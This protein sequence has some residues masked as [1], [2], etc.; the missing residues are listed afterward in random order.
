M[1]LEKLDEINIG[2]R[3]FLQGAASLSLLAALE[4]FTPLYAQ[5][6]NGLAQTSRRSGE[7]IELVIADQKI[8]FDGRT[9]NAIT[10]NGSLPGPVIRLREGEDV[11]IRVTNKLK[12]TSSIHWHGLLV[13]PDMDG[14][15]GVSFAGI[16]PGETFTYRFPVNQYGTYWAHS[17]SGGQELMGVYAPLIIDPIEPEPFK[18]D[19]DHIVMLSD[20]SF[21]SPSRIIANL[22]SLGNYYNFNRRTTAEFFRDVSKKG[23]SELFPITKPGPRCGWTRPI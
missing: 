8:N 3:Y 23:F 21:E 11:V 20:Y 4:R 12:E 10:I 7:A 17:H 16:K 22:K 13:P 9:G 19:R 18:Y 6:N 1:K 14:V 2:R 15:P 5:T